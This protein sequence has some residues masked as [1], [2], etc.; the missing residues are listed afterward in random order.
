MVPTC[1]VKTIRYIPGGR[2]AAYVVRNEKFI[3]R[4]EKKRSKEL[5]IKLTPKSFGV[6][7]CK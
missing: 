7:P 6:K 1:R 3:I 5:S 2:F 4:G